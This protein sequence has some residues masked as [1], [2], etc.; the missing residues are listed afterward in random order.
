MKISIFGL[1]YVGCVT[2]GCLASI[3]HK[4]IG[5]DIDPIKLG[6]IN[7]GKP[8]ITEPKIG[9][10]IKKGIKEKTIEVTEDYSYAVQNSEISFICVGTP[11]K[12]NGDLNLNAVFKVAEN[13]G[14][15]I[16]LKSSYHI[17]C[18][19][20][21]VNPGTNNTVCNML[22]E[23]SGKVPEKD[24]SVVSYPEFLREGSAVDDFF[25]P[26]QTVIGSNSSL[27][28]ERI[29]ELNRAI[30][31]ENIIFTQR[32]V[33]EIIKYVNNSFH[34]I[35][36]GFANE[37]GRIVDC[38]EIDSQELMRVFCLDNKLNL[39]SYY[40]K[41][42]LPF[43]GSCLPKD[44]E[45]LSKLSKDLGQKT[46]LISSVSNSNRFHLDRILEKILQY[47]VKNIGIY[48]LSFKKDTDDLRNSPMIN[49]AKKLVV[50]GYNIKIY[51]EDVNKSKIFG[52]NKDIFNTIPNIDD[53]IKPTMSD[54]VDS[55]DLILLSKKVTDLS[56]LEQ[57]PKGKIILD[58]TGSNSKINNVEG[59]FW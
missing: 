47:G 44:L 10:F 54:I 21:T 6:L 32:E 9:D 28:S 49:L 40:L 2:A 51:D 5:V 37:I 43:G 52:F 57:L 11:P 15:A 24:Y 13:I 38:L 48:G 30:E 20:S 42:G 46:P 33:A 16:K 53:I 14:T 35:K 26:S 58:L 39:S 34:A 12:E 45:A 25:N 50:M 23:V 59:I 1:G 7:S 56:L 36:V 31:V 18:I 22:Q 55:N 8:T 29:G 3:G 17:V 19:R 41:P 4:I 27:A